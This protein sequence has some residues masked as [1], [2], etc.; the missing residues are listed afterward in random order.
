MKRFIDCGLI[1]KDVDS[2][3]RLGIVGNEFLLKFE[4]I[5]DWLVFVLLYFF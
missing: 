2:N 1:I 3:F 4:L 5:I